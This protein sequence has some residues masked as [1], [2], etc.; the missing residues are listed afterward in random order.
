[1]KTSNASLWAV[2]KKYWLQKS[3]FLH[4]MASALLRCQQYLNSQW[5]D[6]S[7]TK[8]G[9][10]LWSGLKIYRHKSKLLNCENTPLD[11][12]LGEGWLY[13]LRFIFSVPS[14]IEQDIELDN[15]KTQL[16]CLSSPRSMS[17][18]LNTPPPSCPQGDFSVTRINY[19][20]L[21]FSVASIS[22]KK[23]FKFSLC[24]STHKAVWAFLFLSFFFSRLFSLHAIYLTISVS[25]NL[26][27]QTHIQ[28]PFKIQ[29]TL[30]QYELFLGCWYV[31]PWTWKNTF[32]CQCLTCAI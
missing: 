21:R 15:K 25:F 26:A 16:T 5:H 10:K 8:N 19:P 4:M 24:L 7:D 28:C 14:H 23:K 3:R 18:S 9:I 1:M 32:R 30:W 31:L 20:M 12:F 13:P 11:I 27:G 29:L 6:I 17:H 22:Y 2:R